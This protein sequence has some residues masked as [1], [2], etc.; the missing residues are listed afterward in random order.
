M[1]LDSALLARYLAQASELGDDVF[2]DTLSAR[3]AHRLVAALARGVPAVARPQVSAPAANYSAT[4][5][6]TTTQTPPDAASTTREQARQQLAA[7]F[8][9]G[10]AAEATTGRTGDVARGGIATRPSTPETAPAGALHVLSS[11][12]Q[13]CV[14][15]GLADGRTHVVFGEGN[16]T[17]DVVIVGEAPGQEEDR[18][19]RPFVGRAGKLLDLLLMSAGFPRDEV[20]I[21]NVLKCRPPNNRNPL[22][23][24]VDA[25]TTAWLHA[26]LEAIAPRVVIAVGKFA[27]QTLCASEESVG[28]LRNRIHEYRGT[29]LIATYHPAYL[30]R[31]PEMVRVAW[32]DFQLLRK[33]YDEQ[34]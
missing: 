34:G 18:T 17:A 1:T 26:Q 32:Q 28:R 8:A 5:T 11:E 10:R 19:G 22:P 30:L 23:A 7:M 13:T 31:S 4:Q 6:T 16:A 29:P 24:E 27:A 33:V 2:F 3:D 15:C 21:C 9:E 12:A 25:C 20:Y 14:R